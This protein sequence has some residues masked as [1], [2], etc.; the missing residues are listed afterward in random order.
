MGGEKQ[1]GAFH[2]TDVP[3]WH[4]DKFSKLNRIVLCCLMD[5]GPI[6]HL[7]TLFRSML[8]VHIGYDR[9]LIDA[10]AIVIVVS[11]DPIVGSI[12]RN[13]A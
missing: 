4:F 10:C 3:I 5:G 1:N 13:V 12:C 7:C 11:G 8:V 6:L 2:E 9:A